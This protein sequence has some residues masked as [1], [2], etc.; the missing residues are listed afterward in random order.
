MTEERVDRSYWRGCW[1]VV[2]GT[3]LRKKLARAR[4]A[5]TLTLLRSAVISLRSASRAAGSYD[6]SSFSKISS[7]HFLKEH[8]KVL[9][10]SQ[11]VLCSPPIWGI[12]GALG[13][14]VLHRDGDR[15][16][17]ILRRC[18]LKACHSVQNYNS[19]LPLEACSH[20]SAVV[21]ELSS[22]RSLV[23][24]RIGIASISRQTNKRKK[25]RIK[26]GHVISLVDIEDYLCT[27]T[28]CNVEEA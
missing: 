21:Y 17:Y 3:P 8:W 4:S 9:F 7:H 14:D 20:E 18:V 11:R 27:Y 28:G 13:Q 24:T 6:F 10:V 23:A 25:K 15:K 22:R 26:K 1:G 5:D 19:T 2:H 16:G 12:Y